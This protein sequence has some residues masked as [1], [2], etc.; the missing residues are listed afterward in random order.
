MKHLLTL[1]FIV[2]FL[3]ACKKEQTDPT[4]DPQ[5]ASI[6]GKWRYAGSEVEENGKKVW[7]LE[8]GSAVND[9]SIRYDGVMLDSKGFGRC[10]VPRS[11]NLNGTVYQVVPKAEVTV[12]G[13]CDCISCATLQIDQSGDELITTWCGGHRSK[14]V[15]D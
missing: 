1:L 9:M 2:A 4:P 12:N 8:P 3:T 7:H 11:Y 14:Y 13:I 6:V 10:C 5:I 15:R